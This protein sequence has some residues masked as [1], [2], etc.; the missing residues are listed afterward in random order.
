MDAYGA[1]EAAVEW[2]EAVAEAL[3]RRG[4]LVARNKYGHLV[5]V[6]N[7]WGVLGNEAVA[8]ME[9]A[10][11]EDLADPEADPT[12]PLGEVLCLVRAF[13]RK[14]SDFIEVPNDPE[15][16]AAILHQHLNGRPV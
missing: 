2:W 1:H 12:F 9:A 8:A 15:A 4:W 14:H 7:G 13:S 10:I 6:R 11:A 16:A 5:G 3:K